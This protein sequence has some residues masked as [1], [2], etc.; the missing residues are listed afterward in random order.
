MTKPDLLSLLG[1]LRAAGVQ[2]YTDT[3]GEGFTVSFFP[4]EAVAAPMTD[5]K[6]Q[7][8]GLCA[9]GHEEFKHMNGFCTAPECVDRPEACVEKPKS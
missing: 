7:D 8:N 3:P 9:C 4:Q 2:S 5:A 1:D 6:A